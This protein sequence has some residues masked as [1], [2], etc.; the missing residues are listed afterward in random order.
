MPWGVGI[1]GAGPGVG[2][3]HLPTLA[4]LGDRFTVVHVAD[5]GSG[6][7]AALAA[8]VGAATSQ[9]TA[10][11]LADPAVEV[12]AICSPPAEHARQIHESIA[13]GVR[14]IL[15]EKPLATTA[16]EAR[17]VVDA[18]RQAGIPLLVATNHFYDEAWDRAKH[19][20]VALESDVRTISATVALP[21][22]GRFHAA[23]TELA[24]GPAGASSR[25]APDLADP[26]VAAAVVRQ[27]V[28]GLAVH[29]LPAVR[30]LAPDFEGVDFAAAVPPIGYTVGFRSSGVRVLLTAVMLPDGPDPVWRLT[31]GTSTDRV[32]VEFPP[33]FV[34]AGS[35]T[36]RVRRGD[37]RT[38]TYRRD[39]D[40]GY[41]REWRV[42][43]DLLDGSATMEYHEV[44]DDALFAVGLADAAA[45]AIRAGARS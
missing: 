36:V 33:S 26:H 31:I 40:D 5:H 1:I 42:L 22:N 17:S 38:T 37:L 11:L 18:C 41:L 4:R 35:A 43:A 24:P 25:G 32:D 15:C 10:A 6:R 23:V 8:G 20:L 45:D 14:A 9:G 28:L 12:V 2:A 39:A 34:H 30:D 7:A 44:L 19:H 29:D 13:A 21:P 27:L 16:E 3:L